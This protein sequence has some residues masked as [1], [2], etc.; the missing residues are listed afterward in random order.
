MGETQQ[1]LAKWAHQHTHPAAGRPNSV[2]LD[3]MGDTGHRVDLD[4]FEILEKEEDWRRRGITESIWVRQ[5][6]PKLNKSGGLSHCGTD[7]S[8][9]MDHYRPDDGLSDRLKHVAIITIGKMF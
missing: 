2:V 1:P 7:P 5:L 9:S 8:A 3:Q 4:S 6:R